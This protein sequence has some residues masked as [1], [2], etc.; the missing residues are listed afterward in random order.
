MQ[1]WMPQPCFA[2][3]F[4]APD[5]VPSTAL[6]CFCQEL[7]PVFVQRECAIKPIRMGRPAHYR[8]VPQQCLKNFVA[9]SARIVSARTLHHSVQTHHRRTSRDRRYPSVHG[10]ERG[11][12]HMPHLSARIRDCTPTQVQLLHSGRGAERQNL[13]AMAESLPRRSIQVCRRR[14]GNFQDAK[15]AAAKATGKHDLS[16]EYRRWP[17]AMKVVCAGLLDASIQY[18]EVPYRC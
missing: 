1:D 18:L 8:P 9:R 7:S 12:R 14:V 15:W 3:R 17:K 11:A 10:P 5:K 6:T 16:P 13:P 2:S 4:S